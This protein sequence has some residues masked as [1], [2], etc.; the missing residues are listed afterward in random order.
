[1][2]DLGGE[3]R[4]TNVGLAIGHA[5]CGLER[6]PEISLLIRRRSGLACSTDIPSGISIGFVAETCEGIDVGVGLI[7]AAVVESRGQ[8]PCHIVHH[9]G[10]AHHHIHR[11]QI[12]R[13]EFCVHFYAVDAQAR[14]KAKLI[15]KRHS[16]LG[17]GA[18][19]ITPCVVKVR[20]QKIRGIW[21]ANNGAMLCKV[22]V[23]TIEPAAI[24][25]VLFVLY[26]EAIVHAYSPVA[27]K[28][29]RIVVHRSALRRA[30]Q[31]V[32]GHPVFVV[33]G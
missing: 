20:N 12:G 11:I 3:R 1:M 21:V 2:S 31:V 16:A 23:D 28:A 17:E 18:N 33:T 5:A 10:H 24:V 4:I 32:V 19:H 13:N 26:G 15:V 30:A 7:G 25:C 9:D 14:F 6:Q 27:A 22:A 8:H 29:H